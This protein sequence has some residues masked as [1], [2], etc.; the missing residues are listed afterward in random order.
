MDEHAKGNYPFD[1]LIT[2]YDVRDYQNA[3]DDV[4][5]GKTLKAVL[6]WK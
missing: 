1:V 6:V 3:I 2:Y 4:T 5:S